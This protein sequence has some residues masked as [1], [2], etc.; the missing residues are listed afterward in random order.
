MVIK[1]LDTVSIKSEFPILSRNINGEKL[2]YLDNAATSQKPK[3]VIDSIV[4]FYSNSNANV[5][6]G[7]HT[8]SEDATDLYEKARE[9]VAHFI[10]ALP[11]EIIFTSGSTESI[12]LVAYTYYDNSLAWKSSAKSASPRVSEL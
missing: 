9:K 3:Q 2:V 7:V 8:L 1:S 10:N 6:R 12:N 4:S 11:E 5:H